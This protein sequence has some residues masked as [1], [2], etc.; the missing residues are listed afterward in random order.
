MPPVNAAKAELQR[1]KP[2]FSVSIY[3]VAKAT[4]H[5]YLRR[6]CEKQNARL[7]AAATNSK[8]DSYVAAYVHIAKQ[9]RIRNLK[10]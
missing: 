3:V 2:I 6:Q 10:T 1:L 4:T 5:K 8:S 7:K 9:P